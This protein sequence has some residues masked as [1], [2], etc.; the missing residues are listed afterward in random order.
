VVKEKTERS[1]ANKELLNERY[2]KK[3]VYL[4][5]MQLKIKNLS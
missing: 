1:H 2:T 4:K 3:Q 5:E